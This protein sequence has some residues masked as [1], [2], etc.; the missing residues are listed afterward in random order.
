MSTPRPWLPG[1]VD[2]LV[3][4]Y[5]AG[6]W[7]GVH[8]TIDR[9]IEMDLDGGDWITRSEA[10]TALGWYAD[11]FDPEVQPARYDLDLAERLGSVVD[12]GAG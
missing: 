7:N 10:R 4:L 9:M 1:L 12:G 3:V 8:H 2:K 6:D 5:K 11:A